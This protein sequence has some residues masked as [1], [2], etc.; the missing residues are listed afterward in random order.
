M[1]D[2]DQQAAKAV[3]RKRTRSR[4]A[5]PPPAEQAEARPTSPPKGK[6]TAARRSNARTRLRQPAAAPHENGSRALAL[7]AHCTIHEA[8]SLRSSLLSLMDAA[9]SVQLD[10]GALEQ[11][12]AAGIQVLAAFLRSRRRDGAKVVWQSHSTVLAD[13]SRRLGADELLELNGSRE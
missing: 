9:D 2:S 1:Q 10:A 8:A 3:V 4:K 11:I 7:P 5:S 13:A 6:A 12:D